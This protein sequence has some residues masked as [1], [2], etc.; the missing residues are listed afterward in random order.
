MTVVT[1]LIHSQ[2]LIRNL[3]D[4]FIVVYVVLVAKKELH[5]SRD[6]ICNQTKTHFS[7]QDEIMAYIDIL[8]IQKHPIDI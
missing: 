2:F 7:N 3:S 8:S 1:L 6:G 5:Q 4:A